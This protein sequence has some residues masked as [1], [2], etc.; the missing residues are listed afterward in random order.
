[1][2]DVMITSQQWIQPSRMI[3]R[4]EHNWQEGAQQK[5]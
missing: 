2:I 4:I 1:M 5:M 3:A